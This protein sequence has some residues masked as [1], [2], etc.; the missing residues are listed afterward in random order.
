[1]LKQLDLTDEE[2]H[3]LEG[4]REVVAAL[5]GSLADV[6]TPAGPTPKDLGTPSAFIPLTVL[7]DSLPKGPA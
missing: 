5:V 7:H 4:D 3:A 6:P 2:R 1:M